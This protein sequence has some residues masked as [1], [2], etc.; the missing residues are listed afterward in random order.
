MDGTD[1]RG[2]S[3]PTIFG[4]GTGGLRLRPLLAIP[5][6]GTSRRGRPIAKP[7]VWE[8]IGAAHDG[9]SGSVSASYIPGASLKQC[10]REREQHCPDR[11]RG[12][13]PGPIGGM[14]A[15]LRDL[16]A[17]PLR[18]RYRLHLIASYRT[19]RPI[20]RMVDF[21]RAMGALARFCRGDGPR[22]VHIHSAVRG[23]IYRKS[24]CVAGCPG[25]PARDLS[26]A[27]RSG[28]HRRVRGPP[29]SGA[30]GAVRRRHAPSGHRDQ[31]LAGRCPPDRGELRRRGDRR[32]AEPGSG[33]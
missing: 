21:V 31:R 13:S 26:A 4:A 32:G 8:G 19:H 33:A 25:G 16:L 23:S 2:A 17:S 14:E 28:R 9:A 12:A 27:C 1:V 10:A 24:L 22:L 11:S 29:R 30:A 20:R 15:V 6:T 7:S 3:S 5:W 18:T